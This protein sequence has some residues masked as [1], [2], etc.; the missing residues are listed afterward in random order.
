MSIFLHKHVGNL[1][2]NAA[3]RLEMPEQMFSVDL[4]KTDLTRKP[5]P[6]PPESFGF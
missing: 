1:A 4:A 3:T 6:N 2:I 5:D